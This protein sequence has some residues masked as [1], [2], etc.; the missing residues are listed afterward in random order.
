[1]CVRERAASTIFTAELSEDHQVVTTCCKDNEDNDD[2]NRLITVCSSA[3]LQLHSHRMR[4]L[5]DLPWC[6]QSALL[7]LIVLIA[8]TISVEVAATHLGPT[9]QVCDW[10]TDTMQRPHF[11]LFGDSLTQKASDP[12][13]G[14]AASL[15]HDYQ[16]KV[17]IA[18]RALLLDHNA[19]PLNSPQRIAPM[20]QRL[21]RQM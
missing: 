13:G 18:L 9:A 12:D 7:P 17:G 14:W 5:R 8:C 3:A 19:L 2:V 1:M 20:S 21:F 11:V 16:R 10:S 4:K 6:N 15:A